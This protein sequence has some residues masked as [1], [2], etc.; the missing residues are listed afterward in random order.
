MDNMYEILKQISRAF[1]LDLYYHW[2]TS[3]CQQSYLSW[4]SYTFLNISNAKY[5]SAYIGEL[6]VDAMVLLIVDYR[7][8][9]QLLVDFWEPIPLYVV[10]KVA[11]ASFFSN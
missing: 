10:L 5:K 8:E 9:W 3:I 2:P 4:H 6:A 11:A 7:Y 1:P